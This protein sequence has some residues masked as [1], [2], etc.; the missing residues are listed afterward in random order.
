MY[1]LPHLLAP[2]VSTLVSWIISWDLR[3]IGL[4]S[5]KMYALP[6][7]LHYYIYRCGRGVSNNLLRKQIILMSIITDS[8]SGQYIQYMYYN[9]NADAIST[10]KLVQNIEK[11]IALQLIHYYKISKWV[12]APYTPH[13]GLYRLCRSDITWWRGLIWHPWYGRN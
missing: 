4:S 5:C 12:G 13:R 3:Q 9:H 8:W 7:S 2:H 6:H 11:I 1:A 10:K